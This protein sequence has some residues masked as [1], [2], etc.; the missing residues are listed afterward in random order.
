[1]APIGM[2]Y[3]ILTIAAIDASLRMICLLSLQVGVGSVHHNQTATT[4][5]SHEHPPFRQ[6][7]IMT[8]EILQN[9]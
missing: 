7:G 8:A 9:R 3:R 4:R 2:D 1:M 6:R 5:A